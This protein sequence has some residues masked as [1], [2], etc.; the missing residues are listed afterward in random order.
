VEPAILNLTVSPTARLGDRIEV[1]IRGLNVAETVVKLDVPD[2]VVISQPHIEV[3]G[4]GTFQRTIGR[5]VMHV[6]EGSSSYV[7][8]TASAGQLRQWGLCKIL[9]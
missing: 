8:I 3:I 2:T 7:E 9:K 4:S 5:T 6:Q 1:T